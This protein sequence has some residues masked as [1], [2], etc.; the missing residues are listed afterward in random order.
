MGAHAP[1]TTFEQS[2]AVF[3]QSYAVFEQSYAVLM[4]FDAP[5]VSRS[6]W[7]NSAAQSLVAAGRGQVQRLTT[8]LSG[9]RKNFITR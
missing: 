6:L 9:E 7:A 8:I 1:I 5:L 2:Y 3:E 4:N